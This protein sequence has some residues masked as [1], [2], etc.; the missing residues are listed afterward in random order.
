[1]VYGF[2]Q[3]SMIAQM[4]LM[5][6]H[7]YCKNIQYICVFW[8]VAT[9]SIRNMFATFSLS[10]YIR[11][12][13]IHQHHTIMCQKYKITLLLTLCTVTS[14]QFHTRNIFDWIF[15][16]CHTIAPFLSLSLCYAPLCWTIVRDIQ[17]S[18]IPCKCISLYTCV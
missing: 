10:L 17:L 8:H 4:G 18:W 14:Q 3:N 16:L 15:N 1:M 11:I 12:E 13:K 5:K 7:S 9:C 6:M 2:C